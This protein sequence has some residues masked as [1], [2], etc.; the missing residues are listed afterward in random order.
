MALR[1]CPRGLSQQPVSCC[2][3]QSCGSGTQ[4]TIRG[5]W[6]R[7]TLDAL[8]TYH[9]APVSCGLAGWLCMHLMEGGVVCMPIIYRI[10]LAVYAAQKS[11]RQTLL[12]G[13][14]LHTNEPVVFL[15]LWQEVILSTPRDM[16]RLSLRIDRGTRCCSWAII[17]YPCKK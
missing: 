12:E 6:S 4:L 16:A 10:S 2:S 15:E 5:A 1:A 17:S 8:S 13:D 9:R 14:L 3:N 11:W 7:D